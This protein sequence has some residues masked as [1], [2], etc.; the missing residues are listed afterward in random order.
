MK[1]FVF[2]L[3][4]LM[5]A[6]IFATQAKNAEHAPVSNYVG[7]ENW[8]LK[9]LSPDDIAELRRGGGWGLAKAAE[10]NGVPGPAHIIG[11]ERRCSARCLADCGNYRDF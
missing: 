9:S 6:T 4:A 10:L 2:V 7:Q 3:S 8:T 1:K 5:L 11:I